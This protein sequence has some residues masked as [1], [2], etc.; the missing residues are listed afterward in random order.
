MAFQ[1][2]IRINKNTIKPFGVASSSEEFEKFTIGELKERALGLFPGVNG[3]FKLS[4][5]IFTFNE[6]DLEDNQTFKSCG[7]EHLS[8]LVV[9]LRMPG[10][11][12]MKLLH[13]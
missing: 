11:G 1:V 8:L 4:F 12:G 3:N 5:A 9:V 6:G 10:G 2:Q 13:V 7:I